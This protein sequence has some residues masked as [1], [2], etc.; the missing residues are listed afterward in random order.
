MLLIGKNH[1]FLWAIYTMAMLVITR[2]Y[3]MFVSSRDR[4]QTTCAMVKMMVKV[5]LMV[6]YPTMRNPY[7]GYRHL[8][9]HGLMTQKKALERSHWW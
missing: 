5:C 3:H 2:G 6:I 9:K 8:K 7:N 4:N 1:L